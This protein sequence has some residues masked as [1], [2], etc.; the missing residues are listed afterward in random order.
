[1]KKEVLCPRIPA[2]PR[3]VSPCLR[4]SVS[5]RPRVSASRFP[6]S[7]RPALP[8]NVDSINVAALMA[9]RLLALDLDGTLLN[10]KGELTSRNRE[11]IAKVRE[12]DVKVALVTGRRFPDARPLALELGIDV[13]V[14]AHN[15]ALTKHA[16]TLETVAIVPL[17][18]GA[19]LEALQI[20]RQLKA[21]L[22]VSD[23]R[24]G[25]GIMV[26][27]HLSGS[28][29]ALLRYVAWA[30]RVHGEEGQN[31][32][33]EVA[34]LEDYLDHDPVHVAFSGSCSAMAELEQILVQ[35]LADRVRI[36]RTAYPRI[37]FTLLDLVHPQVSKGVGVA[38][39]ANELCIEREEVMAIGDNFNDLEMLRFAGIG[40]VMGNADADLRQVP[41]LY[42]TLSNDAD[43]VALAID[44]FI[45]D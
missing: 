14:I 27:D 20:G 38:A 16:E 43:G 44:E 33:L 6:A 11:T 34:S 18:F 42:S 35:Q 45:F 22:L 23:E 30:K 19:A 8:F 36:F 1:M 39:V 7:P 37:D 41:G 25:R 24:D 29:P 3:P 12:K 9:I 2:S 21:D 40:V 4:V 13:P 32:V 28:N 5:P 26:Y 17:P 15:G 31:G 10:S